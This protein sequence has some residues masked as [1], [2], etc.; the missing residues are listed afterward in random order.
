[1]SAYPALEARFNQ[2]ATPA[3]KAAIQQVRSQCN[4]P[5]LEDFAGDNLETTT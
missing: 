1:M 5:D 4:T 2:I 3:G